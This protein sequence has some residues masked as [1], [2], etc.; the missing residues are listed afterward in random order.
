MFKNRLATEAHEFY[1]KSVAFAVKGDDTLALAY[2]NR[3]AVLFEKGL[4]E[5]CLR[6]STKIFTNITTKSVGYVQIHV[7]FPYFFQTPT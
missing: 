4:Y 7:A 2:A 5:E 6:V 1:T 3:S